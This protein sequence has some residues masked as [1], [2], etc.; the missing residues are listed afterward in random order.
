MTL[1]TFKKIFW[2]NFAINILLNLILGG[3]A[4]NGQIYKGKYFLSEHGN[5]TEVSAIIY[6]FSLVHTVITFGSFITLFVAGLTL[7]ILG[8]KPEDLFANQPQSDDQD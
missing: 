1:K 6:Y 2:G 8:K 7:K 5:Q 3:D 4:L